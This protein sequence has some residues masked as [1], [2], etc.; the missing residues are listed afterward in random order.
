M[1]IYERDNIRRKLLTETYN[2]S[3]ADT[4]QPID[5]KALGQSLN[6]DYSEIQKAY[7]YLK[8]ENLLEP[9]GTGYTVTISHFGIKTVESYLR[10]IDFSEDEKFTSTEVFQLR[11]MLDE[12]KKE[13]VKVSFGQQIIFDE[14]EKSFERSK[15]ENKIDWKESLEEKIK[16][17][18]VN[19]II[20]ES[21]SLMF[22]GILAGLKF[23]NE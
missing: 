13:L 15:V 3:K 4:R 19:K 7:Y 20:D 11:I 17:W 21:S 14:I 5:L 23:V 2:H 8:D 6:I 1:N 10:K 18:T 12:I 16:D 9:Y 22:Q